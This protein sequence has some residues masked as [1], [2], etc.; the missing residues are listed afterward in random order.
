MLLVCAGY[1]AGAL[2]GQSL[3]FPELSSFAP[4]AT[5]RHF[6]GGAAA[7]A[8]ATMVDI[9]ACR[10]PGAYRRATERRR[11]GLGDLQSTHW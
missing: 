1:Y 7:R 4:L 11:A 5:H 9:S 2:I 8:A 10:R 3:R 6:V